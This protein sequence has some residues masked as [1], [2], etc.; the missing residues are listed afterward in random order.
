MNDNVFEVN[1]DNPMLPHFPDGPGWYYTNPWT[2]VVV[3]P[4]QEKQEAQNGFDQEL[5][6]LKDGDTTTTT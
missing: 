6:S 3:G 2:Q 1:K 5:D 4:F